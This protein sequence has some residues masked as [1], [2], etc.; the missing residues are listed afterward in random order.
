MILSRCDPLPLAAAG[1]VM[2][3][4]AWRSR[5]FMRIASVA[6]LLVCRR[7]HACLCFS[8]AGN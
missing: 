4:L 5:H 8:L 3:S 1:L 7:R 2:G 6:A